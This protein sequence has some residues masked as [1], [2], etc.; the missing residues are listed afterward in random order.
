MALKM[1]RRFVGVELKESYY[2]QAV[3]NLGQLEM[4]SALFDDFAEAS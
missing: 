1:D 3:A 4:Q 2:K